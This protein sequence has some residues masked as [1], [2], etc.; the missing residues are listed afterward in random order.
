M[1]FLQHDLY[2]MESVIYKNIFIKPDMICYLNNDIFLSST[3][4][5]TKYKRNVNFTH[6]KTKNFVFRRRL[7]SCAESFINSNFLLCKGIFQLQ[8]N[9]KNT[10]WILSSILAFLF[11]HLFTKPLISR[12]IMVV[13]KEETE[14][15]DLFSSNLS[16]KSNRL[17][18][19]WN[20]K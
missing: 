20:I 12:E 6:L 13:M 18:L 7:M 19:D 3:L 8:R 14:N 5:I 1:S 10:I 11:I 15:I 2:F 16:K 9:S 4:S 17:F